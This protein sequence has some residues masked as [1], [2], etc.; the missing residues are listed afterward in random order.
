M[1]SVGNLPAPV[2]NPPIGTAKPILSREA[3][4]GWPEPPLPFR[5]EAYL[6]GHRV[7]V[8]EVIDVYRKARFIA[9]TAEHFGWPDYLV[10]CARL[11][12]P[13]CWRQSVSPV[14]FTGN[15]LGQNL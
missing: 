11:A 7:A 10:K 4:L 1:G 8:W 13:L 12:P 15:L 14:K 2:G 6:P 3:V 5:Q 9:R